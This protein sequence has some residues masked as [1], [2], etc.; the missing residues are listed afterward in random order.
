MRDE[1]REWLHDVVL[2]TRH[3]IH[4]GSMTFVFLLTLTAAAEGLLGR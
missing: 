3:W 2:Y 4:Y 1:H